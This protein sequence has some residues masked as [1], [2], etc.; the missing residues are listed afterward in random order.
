MYALRAAVADTFVFLGMK[1]IIETIAAITRRFHPPGTERILRLFYSPDKV[2]GFETTAPY[3]GTL[4]I[5]INPSSFFE[6]QIF[7]KGQYGE[8][9]VNVIQKYFPKGGVF[10]DVGAN[11]GLYSLV[12]AKTAK[13]VIAIEPVPAVVERLRKN[14]E[15]NSFTNISIF[16]G[17]A[18]DKEGEKTL[19]FETINPIKSSSVVFYDASNESIQVKSFVLDF[20]LAGKKVDFIKIDTDGH[21]RNV[22]MGAKKIIEE[23]RPVV[24]F[25]DAGGSQPN[26]ISRETIDE[27]FA[28]AGYDITPIGSDNFLCVPNRVQKH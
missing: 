12:A 22:I 24:I 23:Q 14:S 25:E 20:L 1:K 7:F 11:I 5:C 13:E 28:N 10:V 21:D 8:N 16:H 18:S 6:W 19:Y 15:L 2:K 4:R 9:I 17:V 3:S 26:G 27:F